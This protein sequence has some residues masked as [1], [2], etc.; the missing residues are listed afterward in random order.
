MM[1][2]YFY[3]LAKRIESK[4]ASEPESKSPRK[5]FALEVARLGQRL[6]DEENQVAWCGVAA[7]FDLLSA[8][9]VT[10]CFVEF[11]GGI[12]AA[13]GFAETFL[14]EAEQAGFGGDTCG[15]HRTV[16]GAARKGLMPSP[17]FLIAT[18]CPC[19]GGQAAV[20][21]LARYF[22]KD[23]F[24]LNVPQEDTREGVAYLADQLRDMVRF[25]S[26][27]TGKSL[28]EDRLRE[29][30]DLTN[31]ARKTLLDVYR[32]ASS[33]PSPVNGKLLSNFGIIMNL[34]L[35]IPAGVD[36]A[37]TFRDDFAA[38]VQEGLSGI[39][40][41]RIRLMWIQ[42]RI[43]FQ[44]P[45]V[46][47]MEDRYGAVVVVD[48]LN[49]INWEPIDSDDPFASMALRAILNP[50]NGSVGRRIELLQ[51]LAKTYR[52]D[53]AINPCHWGCRQGT[54]SRGMLAQGLKDIDVPVLNLEVDCVDTR[55]F[56]EGQ[57]ATR[58]EAFVEI[59][60]NRESPWRER[61]DSEK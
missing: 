15:Y 10:S 33:V 27:H 35:G 21:N 13:T 19:S 54:G 41:E 47:M 56:A 6:Y 1:K 60:Q 4:L 3:D 49:D 22:D 39:D 12:L 31:E 8:M 61:K 45:L 59:L 20:E 51:K 29:T 34:F 38:K 53:G 17:S 58:L 30:V 40:E 24:M 52:V 2:Q 55:N 28:N 9:D 18:S 44:Q 36:V 11:V 16:M 14:E 7:P 46:Q 32:L 43:Q 50:F 25:V 42:N 57:L 23:L 37:R 48:E 26:D 5:I